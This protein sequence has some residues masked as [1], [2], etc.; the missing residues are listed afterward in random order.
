MSDDPTSDWGTRTKG[1][2]I[3]AQPGRLVIPHAPSK[4]RSAFEAC[5]RQTR[6]L[7]KA[8]PSDLKEPQHRLLPVLA[9]HTMKGI[10][11]GSNKKKA[12]EGQRTGAIDG[13]ATAPEP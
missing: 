9:L 10:C 13:F 6:D 11:L 2:A 7:A 5:K 4:E 12:S 8:K 1:P 3:P